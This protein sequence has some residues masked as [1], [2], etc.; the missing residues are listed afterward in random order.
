MKAIW[1]IGFIAC[2]GLIGIGIINLTNTAE[3]DFTVAVAA[4]TSPEDQALIERATAVLK[5]R[6]PLLSEHAHLI[7]EA[8]GVATG[9]YRAPAEDL[10]WEREVEIAVKLRDNAD[11]LPRRAQTVRAS[12]HT[13]YYFVGF[14]G[15]EG[16]DIMKDESQ[17]MCADDVQLGRGSNVFVPVQTTKS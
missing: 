12:G 3:A 16:I 17:A 4:G 8:R 10:G 1:A 2:L 11:G 15:Q 5:N 9:I 6:C 13:L 7:V 14:G